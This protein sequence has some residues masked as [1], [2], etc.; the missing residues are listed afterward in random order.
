[1]DFV[2]AVVSYP[3]RVL[4][5]C[6]RALFWPRRSDVSLLHADDAPEW[7]LE[8]KKA[9]RSLLAGFTPFPLTPDGHSQSCLALLFSGDKAV[10]YERELM[11]M[12][13]QEVVALDWARVRGQQV[14]SDAAICILLPTFSGNSEDLRAMAGCA[15]RHGL[16]A[17]V[18][19]KRGHAKGQNLLKP[20]LLSFG[21]SS[22]LRHIIIELQKRHPGIPIV[23]MGSSAGGG[24]LASYLQGHPVDSHLD[25]LVCLSPGYDTKQLFCQGG[26]TV[27]WPYDRLLLLGQQLLVRKNQEAL[28]GRLSVGEVMK[29][30][31]L[32][33][34]TTVV[35]LPAYGMSSLDEYWDANNPLRSTFPGAALPMMCVNAR[36]DPVVVE[37]MIPKEKFRGESWKSAMLVLS[38]NGGHCGFLEGWTGGRWDYR[39]GCAFLQFITSAARR[40]KM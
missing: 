31:T 25:A 9:N 13:D 37:S 34:F 8:F 21:D 4:W 23:A 29:C 14:A 35:E 7:M 6:L 5:S 27:P 26:G 30:R 11:E 38:D 3:V 12:K 2:V 16:R 19:N 17:V 10:T 28:A 39:V 20:K 36:D 1:M 24:L 32:N 22:D 18:Y 33:E 15:V 40:G